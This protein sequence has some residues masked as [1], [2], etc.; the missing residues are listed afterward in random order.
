[1]FLLGNCDID[2]LNFCYR[3][4]WKFKILNQSKQAEISQ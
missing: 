4:V 1:M 3:Q 2:F